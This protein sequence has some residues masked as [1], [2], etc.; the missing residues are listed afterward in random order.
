MDTLTNFDKFDAP[1][2]KFSD[3]PDGMGDKVQV[4]D[5]ITATNGADKA[6]ADVIEI[7]KTAGEIYLSKELPNGDFSVE[8]KSSGQSAP[9]DAIKKEAQMPKEDLLTGP[10]PDLKKFL[11]SIQI[12]EK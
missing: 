5:V 12:E 8:E 1:C 3:L 9:Y 10:L 2:I 11:I 6:H 7:D 4:G